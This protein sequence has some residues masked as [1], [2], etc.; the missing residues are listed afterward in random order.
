MVLAVV[1]GVAALLVGWPWT[2]PVDAPTASMAL[3]ERREMLLADLAEL[4]LD[5]AEGRISAAD[6]LE[7]RRAL[8]PEL[9]ALSEQLRALGQPGTAR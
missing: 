8:A 9:R 6:R 4:D 3:A 5:L 2:R 1:A 7:G